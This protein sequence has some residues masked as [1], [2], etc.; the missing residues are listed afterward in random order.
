[1]RVVKLQ[2]DPEGSI[3]PWQPWTTKLVHTP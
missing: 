1:L 2:K 3:D